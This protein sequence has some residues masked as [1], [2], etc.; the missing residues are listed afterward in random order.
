MVGELRDKAQLVAG[1]TG[2]PAR[3]QVVPAE[4]IRLDLTREQFDA[5]LRQWSVSARN[6]PTQVIVSVDSESV[7]VLHVIASHFVDP[8]AA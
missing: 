5:V 4:P 3:T 6:S 1:G 8:S 2:G 7:G